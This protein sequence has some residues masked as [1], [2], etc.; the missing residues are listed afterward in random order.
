MAAAD[1]DHARSQDDGVKCGCR[2]AVA[3]AKQRDRGQT[4]KRQRFELSRSSRVLKRSLD[5]TGAGVST[6]VF[7]PLMLFTALAVRLDS[8]GSALFRQVRVGRDGE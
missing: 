7:A 3:C 5:L 6:I 4:A 1:E 2:R 8:K